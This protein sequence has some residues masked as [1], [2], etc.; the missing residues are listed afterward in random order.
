MHFFFSYQRTHTSPGCFLWLVGWLIGL[1]VL[2]FMHSFNRDYS[3]SPILDYSI[4]QVFFGEK[5][6]DFFFYE[7]SII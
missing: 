3:I 7:E 1:F 2:W 5:Y 4:S 6:G